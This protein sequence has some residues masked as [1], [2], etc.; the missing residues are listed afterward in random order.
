MEEEDVDIAA[1]M[2]FSSF[3]GAKKRKHDQTNS[4]KTKV[5]ASGA[6]S[7]QLGVRTKKIVMEET[8]V[9][10][11]SASL[12]APGSPSSSAQNRKAHT[13]GG[14][15]LASFLA[16]AQSHTEQPTNVQQAS[17]CA[18]EPASSTLETVCFGGS[19]ITKAELNALRFGCRNEDG[20]MAYFLPSFVEDPWEKLIKSKS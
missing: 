3:G 4:P 6:N 15:G 17:D 16:R 13:V 5:D 12:A 19:V 10:T 9:D 20:D 18:S 11:A 1:A 2:G 14:T 7:T 8:S